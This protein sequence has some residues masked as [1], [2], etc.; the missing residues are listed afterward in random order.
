MSAGVIFCPVCK[1]TIDLEMDFAALVPGFP[2]EVTTVCRR[3]GATLENA[4]KMDIDVGKVRMIAGPTD[5]KWLA[6]QA[7]YQGRRLEDRVEPWFVTSCLPVHFI[8]R[9]EVWAHATFRGRE[10]VTDGYV[11]LRVHD[12]ASFRCVNENSGT[13]FKFLQRASENSGSPARLVARIVGADLRGDLVDDYA[14]L[15]SDDG[16]IIFL[17]AAHVEAILG[18]APSAQFLVEKNG[19]FAVVM[20]DGDLYATL[21][22]LEVDKSR[23]D[24]VAAFGG[25]A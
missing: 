13:F 16:R 7:Y 17:V 23:Y 1:K 14:A 12:G 22:R 9:D 15:K 3:C 4:V 10:Y 11:A 19:D 6:F 5:D 20:V 18:H 25:A 21:A 2:E 24:Q 8:M